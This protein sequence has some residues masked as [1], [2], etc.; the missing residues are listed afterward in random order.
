MVRRLPVV[1]T[2]RLFDL[3]VHKC[4]VTQAQQDEPHGVRESVTVIKIICIFFVLHSR[5]AVLEGIQIFLE[6]D[7]SRIFSFQDCIWYIG[8]QSEQQAVSIALAL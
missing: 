8:W 7:F 6:A 1:M 5:I 2:H 3:I 4:R